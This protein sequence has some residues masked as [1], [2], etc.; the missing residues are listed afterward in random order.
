MLDSSAII[1]LHDHFPRRRVHS[2]LK[3]VAGQRRLKLPEGVLR[4]MRRKTKHA[5]KTVEQ[6][7]Q[8]FPHSLVRIAHVRSLP[9]ELS[10]IEQAYGN[11]IRIG[12]RVYPGFWKSAR[13][14]RAVDGQVVATA[15]KLRATAVSDDRAIRGACLLEG[16]PC[17][18]WTEFARIL[19]LAQQFLFR[20]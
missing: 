12:N 5:K 14:R 7:V 13:G 20:G 19:G 3:D 9:T 4:E 2:A 11:Q 16:I 17:I 8:E 15:K 6:L 18:G 10:R 1:D